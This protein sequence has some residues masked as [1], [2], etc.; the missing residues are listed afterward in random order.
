MIKTI[1]YWSIRG[2]G[3]H[4]RAPEEAMDDAKK[5]GFAG[6][7]LAIAEKGVLT[8][9]TDQATCERWRKAAADKGV[10]M[11]TLAS[12]MSWG[13]CPTHPD[14]AVRKKA[15]AIHAAALQRAAW[16]GCEAM[17]FVPGAVRV[18]WI[19]SFPPVPYEKAMNWAR[20]AVEA[21]L[22]VAEKVG[23]DL[24]V[25]NVWNGLLLS[26]LEWRDLLDRY[27]SPRLGMYFD[28]GNYLAYHQYPPHWIELLGKRIR[29]IH[30]KDY[31][32]KEGF[33]DLLKGDVPWKETMAA[34]KKVG[35]R[36]TI[37]A[38]MMP[39][40]DTLLA[41]TSQALDEILAM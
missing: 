5:A 21:L 23:V 6:I 29:R 14:A 11:Q 4:S 15:I 35:Y 41:R 17:L 7:E 16:L 22:P 13:C 18:P 28:V 30:I 33:V 39:Y 26:P 40:D 32:Y 2:G 20:E 8:P 38:E 1:S 3:D 34:L 36:K 10:I 27:K 19:P 24:C 12:G 25:E 37:V 9:G 31:S